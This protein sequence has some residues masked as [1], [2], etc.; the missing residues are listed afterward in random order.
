MLPVDWTTP[1]TIETALRNFRLCKLEGKDGVLYRMRNAH[2]A[3]AVFDACRN[4]AQ[5]LQRSASVPQQE[6]QKGWGGPIAREGLGNILLC[7]ACAP[8]CT[9]ADGTGHGTFT[10]RILRVSNCMLLFTTCPHDACHM[11]NQCIPMEQAVSAIHSSPSQHCQP[12][13][14]LIVRQQ[15]QMPLLVRIACIPDTADANSPGFSAS[16]PFCLHFELARLLRSWPTP[17]ACL[18]AYLHVQHLCSTKSVMCAFG[19]AMAD[20][21]EVTRGTQLPQDPDMQISDPNFFQFV[22]VSTIV[23]AMLAGASPSLCIVLSCLPHIIHRRARN[24]VFTLSVGCAC[25]RRG[26][27]QAA[28]SPT[29]RA[30]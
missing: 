4:V 15:W 16:L 23:L 10:D 14:M 24:L 22:L 25:C 30:R 29:C 7:H 6:Q 2:A 3:I 27:S 9:A 13:G 20:V 1:T 5:P 12:A 11:A 21:R 18:P 17:Y 19:D 28:P 8:R 26:V